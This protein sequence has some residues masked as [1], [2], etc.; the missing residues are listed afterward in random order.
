LFFAVG[1]QLEKS[2]APIILCDVVD[3]DVIL[4]ETISTGQSETIV[5]NIADFFPALML[6]NR[7]RVAEVME[8]DSRTK[9]LGG[10]AAAVRE[11]FSPSQTAQHC[12]PAV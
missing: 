2:A 6:S 9:Q 7:M 8:A 5:I 12:L 11:P 10:I 1:L 4:V 3:C